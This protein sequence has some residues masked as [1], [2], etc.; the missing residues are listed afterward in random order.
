MLWRLC[1]PPPGL[2]LGPP[3]LGLVPPGGLLCTEAPATETA[4][5][6]ITVTAA[7]TSGQG[8]CGAQRMTSYVHGTRQAN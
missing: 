4:V 2:F 3:N 6:M 5:Q 7:G 8:D 1:L